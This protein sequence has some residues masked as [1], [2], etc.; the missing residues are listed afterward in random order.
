MPLKSQSEYDKKGGILFL[1]NDGNI[2][3]FEEK[4]KKITKKI[5]KNT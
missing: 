4:I 2:M 1:P 3:K 5:K